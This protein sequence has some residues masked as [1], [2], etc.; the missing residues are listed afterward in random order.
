[1]KA[2]DLQLS[3]Y[4]RTALSFLVLVVYDFYLY[5]QGKII[6]CSF[7]ML[8]DIPLVITD[9][10]DAAYFA[11]ALDRIAVPVLF[12]ELKFYLCLTEKY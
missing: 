11:D 4:P 10:A 12:Y 7:G 6:Q 2:R 9:L 5:D 3:C 8:P 1:M